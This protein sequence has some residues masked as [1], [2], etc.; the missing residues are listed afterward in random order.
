MTEDEK[1]GGCP[2]LFH[3]PV[4]FIKKYAGVECLSTSYDFSLAQVPF[5]FMTLILHLV[6]MYLLFTYIKMKEI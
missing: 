4:S 1:T 2:L 3:E 5:L 6:Y